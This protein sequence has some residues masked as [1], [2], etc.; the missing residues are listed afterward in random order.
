MKPYTWMTSA[1]WG[2]SHHY[3]APQPFAPTW[4]K[5]FLGYVCL[6]F[7]SQGLCE[8][9]QLRENRW[10][11]EPCR[12]PASWVPPTQKAHQNHCRLRRILPQWGQLHPVE[13]DNFSKGSKFQGFS[14]Q[15][16]GD[17]HDSKSILTNPIVRKKSSELDNFWWW[18]NTIRETLPWSI[19]ETSHGTHLPIIS[20]HCITCFFS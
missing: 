14:H 4:N 5:A 9:P 16:H 2:D 18:S 11:P 19:G 12:L 17:S 20:K 8:L 10:K 13:D 6:E 15:H 3:S 1:F 7:C